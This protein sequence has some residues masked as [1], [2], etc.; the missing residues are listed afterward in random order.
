MVHSVVL[1]L[2]DLLAIW[3]ELELSEKWKDLATK[4]LESGLD[5]GTWEDQDQES[6]VVQEQW[7]GQG[8]WEALG[9]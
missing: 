8:T 9:I 1:H 2:E 7:E 3:M 5:M 4:E 6:W